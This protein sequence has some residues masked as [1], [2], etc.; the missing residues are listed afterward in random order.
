M[1]GRTVV[2]TGAAGGIGRATA[3]LFAAR[4]ASVWA[5]D[6]DADG[7]AGTQSLAG[8]AAGRLMARVADVADDAALRQAFSEF[9]AAGGIDVLV[10][11]AGISIDAPFLECTK[12]QLD[13][14]YRCKPQRRIPLRSGSSTQ[15]D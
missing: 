8:E 14:T 2:V 11:N 10:A 4:G 1:E 15:H 3:L 12:E 13:R 7:L 5:V 9:D 6:V